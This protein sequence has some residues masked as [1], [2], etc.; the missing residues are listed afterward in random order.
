MSSISPIESS[1]TSKALGAVEEA[2]RLRLDTMMRIT[3]GAKISSAKDAP[4]TTGVS[5]NLSARG[6][7]LEADRLSLQN[8]ASF[9]QAQAGAISQI[10][11]I[12]NEIQALTLTVS[13]G[14]SLQDSS[15][16]GTEADDFRFSRGSQGMLV[17]QF[18]QKVDALWSVANQTMG[19]VNL[20]KTQVGVDS[21]AD[22]VLADGTSARVTKYD[23]SSDE[24]GGSSS[25]DSLSSLVRM[26]A[27]GGSGIATLSEWL[28]FTVYADDGEE[29]RM[30][31][32]ESALASMI[33]RNGSELLAV[34]D[35]ADRMASYSVGNSVSLGRIADSNLAEDM[36]QYASSNIRLYA[37]MAMMAQSKVRPTMAFSL[38]AGA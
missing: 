6:A 14:V 4:G 38:I 2:L 32:I 13:Q 21:T 10:S 11:S 19:G 1:L 9:L 28:F 12:F 7:R 3:S 15:L 8:A 25:V 16:T 23:F 36:T 33:T 27:P 37:S 31:S 34:Q 17:D 29:N 35:A 5:V 24:S 20:F 18:Y 26:S 30:T 22:L